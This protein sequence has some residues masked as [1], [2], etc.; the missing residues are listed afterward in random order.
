M[1]K[2]FTILLILSLPGTAIASSPDVVS[3][4]L[5]LPIS[6]NIKLASKGTSNDFKHL[7]NYFLQEG[8]AY[9]NPVELSD[10]YV[11]RITVAKITKNTGFAYANVYCEK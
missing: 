5:K 9:C 4:H 10:V 2:V 1:K 3:L 8:H 7:T 6:K 11:S